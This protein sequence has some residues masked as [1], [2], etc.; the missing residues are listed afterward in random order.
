MFTSKQWVSLQWTPIIFSLR[1]S[2][3]YVA[4]SMSLLVGQWRQSKKMIG[5]SMAAPYPLDIWYLS[6]ATS[7][8]GGLPL[9]SLSH[10]LATIE[11]WLSKKLT[12]MYTLCRFHVCTN[13]CG[14]FFFFTT[15]L[16][17]ACI[18]PVTG[19]G[20]GLDTR[21]QRYLSSQHFYTRVALRNSE[22]TS[23]SKVEDVGFHKKARK[24]SY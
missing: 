20:G 16:R 2:H 18:Q 10:R 1:S 17:Y 6:I 5:A 7:R 3:S 4:G 23:W 15:N 19:Q 22:T 24:V 21:H 12:S 8:F 13:S 14:F 9:A 11:A